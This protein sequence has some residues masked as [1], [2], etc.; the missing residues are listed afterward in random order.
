MH[1]RISTCIARRL[2]AKSEFTRFAF[3][4][5]PGNHEPSEWTDRRSGAFAQTKRVLFKPVLTRINDLWRT[6]IGLDLE[7]DKETLLL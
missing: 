6:I 3:D 1:D 5:H 7:R 4:E 2:A